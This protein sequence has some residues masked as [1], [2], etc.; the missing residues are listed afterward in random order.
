[1]AYWLSNDMKSSIL[2][3]LEGHW[4]PVRSAILATAGLLVTCCLYRKLGSAELHTRYV[5]DRDFGEGTWEAFCNTI[6]AANGRKTA[7]K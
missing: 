4:Q 5:C 1:V 3:D 6:N 7:K 2:H